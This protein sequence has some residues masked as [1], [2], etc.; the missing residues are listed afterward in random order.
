MEKN[1]FTAEWLRRKIR[2]AIALGPGATMAMKNALAVARQAPGGLSIKRWQDFCPAEAFT[3]PSRW[4]TCAELKRYIQ[5]GD[6][7]ETLYHWSPDG[8]VPDKM[9]GIREVKTIKSEYIE[10]GAGRSRLD[11]RAKDIKIGLGGGCF[12]LVNTYT[13]SHTAFDTGEQIVA[14]YRLHKAPLSGAAL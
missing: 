14:I 2:E 4:K 10:V 13:G 1:Q 3:T 11:F 7:I 8:S 9:K 12:M 5:P 6:G